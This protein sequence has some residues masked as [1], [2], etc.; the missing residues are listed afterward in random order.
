MGFIEKSAGAKTSSAVTVSILAGPG[1]TGTR[2]VIKTVIIN[3][4]DTVTQV[5]TLSVDLLGVN[6]QL[7]KVTMAPGDTLVHDI[8]LVLTGTND[9]LKAV[10]GG[11]ITTNQMDIV[12]TYAEVSA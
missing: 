12:T 5:L 7:L 11:A 10:L 1:V 6:Y 3:N 2:E 4:R 9:V 8:P